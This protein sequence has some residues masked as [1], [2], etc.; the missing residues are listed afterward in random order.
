MESSASS[1]AAGD[2]VCF[3]KALAKSV[4]SSFQEAEPK[5]NYVLVQRTNAVC[6]SSSIRM[7]VVRARFQLGR[8]LK[9]QIAD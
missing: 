6:I 4:R 2:T 7:I 5:M 8:A 3:V 9:K 1:A